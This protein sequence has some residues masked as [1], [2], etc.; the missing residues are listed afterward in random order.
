MNKTKILINLALALIVVIGV[1]FTLQNRP[2]S[3][4]APVTVQTLPEQLPSFALKDTEGTDRDSSEWKGKILIV[5]FWATWCPPCLEEMPLLIEFQG[6]YSSRG[7][8]VVGVAVDNL[9]QVK[10]FM[11]VYG[12]NFPVLVGSDDA[13]ALAQRM[14]NRISSLPYTAIFDK[15]GRTLYAQPGKIT[16]ETLEKA[17]KSLP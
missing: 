17:L 9:Q 10:D 4:Q 3:T 1:W 16:R 6:Q 13:I 11:D 12:I 2:A 7:V 8:Q 5:N 15:D 14:G